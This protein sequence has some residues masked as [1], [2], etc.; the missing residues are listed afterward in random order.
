[1]LFNPQ[2]KKN[3][4]RNK[5][6]AIWVMHIFSKKWLEKRETCRWR[7]G[8]QGILL[9]KN[10]CNDDRAG[11]GGKETTRGGENKN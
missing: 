8:W 11:K 7:N 5:Y 3:E 6:T 2:T 10:T 4:D 9:K 1:M